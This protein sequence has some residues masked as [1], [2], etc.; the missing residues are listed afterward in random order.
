MAALATDL[1]RAAILD[2]I[3]R[4]RTYALTGDR[5]EVDFTVDGAPMGS[6]IEAGRQVEVAYDVRGRDELEVVEVIQDGVTVH[7][8][9]APEAVAPAAALGSPLQARL[10]WGWGPWAALAL[11]RVTDWR[12][13][14][15]VEHGRI[16]RVFPCLQSGPFDEQRRHRFRLDNDRRLDIQSYTARKG[17]YREN[18]NQSVVLELEGGPDLVLRLALSEPVAAESVARAA[19]LLAESRNDAVGPFPRESY[20][21][22]RLVPRAASSL[23][24]RCTLPVSAS[25]SS[26]Y[27]RVKQRNGHMAWVSPVFVNYR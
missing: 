19:D 10:E 16:R 6:S 9:H 7:R 17:A 27:L 25:R 4:R 22:H 26:V 14:V 20:Q 3:R 23:A 11:D 1:T 13:A 12:L 5:I 18:P 21:W 15:T 8:D 2:A 24:G